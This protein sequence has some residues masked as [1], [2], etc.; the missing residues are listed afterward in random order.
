MILGEVLDLKESLTVEFKE[1]CLK[2]S[3]YD[4]YT[5]QEIDAI[6]MSG[7]IDD[8][9]TIHF[10]EVMYDGIQR[11]IQYYLPKYAS[12]FSNCKT[13]ND[14][15]STLYVGINDF[16]EVTG[17]PI[18]GD[19][20]V[21]RIQSYVDH[22]LTSFLRTSDGQVDTFKHIKLHVEKLDIDMMLLTDARA[23]M[24]QKLNADEQ[25]YV[26]E[27]T[28]YLRD[29]DDWLKKLG[30]YTCKLTLM[31]KNKND[32]IVA[33]IK[34]KINT[35][36]DS[37][38]LNAAIQHTRQATNTHLHLDYDTIMLHKDNP[39]HFIYWLLRFK[40]DTISMVLLNRPKQP[41]IPRTLNAMF[42]LLTQLTD[43]RYIFL[44]NNTKISYYVLKIIYEYDMPKNLGIEYKHP[45]KDKWE[46]RKRIMHPV[47]GPCLDFFYSSD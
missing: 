41:T 35:D 15:D 20:D 12:G 11:Y 25:Q 23:D 6:V 4:F 32:E 45:Y 16:S 8:K 3:L 5:R 2:R 31:L 1:F 9:C 21:E 7:V 24:I 22:V 36:I 30:T 13:N 33:Y 17:I 44:Q 37:R 19:I 38:T 10:N 39:T 28:Q 26:T 34:T 14:S 27:Y 47:R 29:R 46:A 40:D 43:M 18:I 42:Y